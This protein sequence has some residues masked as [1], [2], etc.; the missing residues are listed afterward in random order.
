MAAT[1]ILDRLFSLSGR[2]ALVTGAA[3]GFGLMMARGMAEAGAHVVLNDRDGRALQHSVAALTDEGLEVS[4][5]AFDVTDAAAVNSAVQAIAGQ[6]GRLDI[7]INNAAIQN[8]KPVLE[9]SAEEWRA[10]IETDLTGCFLVAQAAARVM[11]PQGSGRIINIA[12]IV[13][14]VGRARLAP[15]TSA[16][17]GLEGLTRVL[18]AEFGASGITANA[19]APG[20]F[21]TDFNQA[22]LTDTAFVEWVEGRTPTGRWGDPEDLLGA[23]IY[24]ASDAAAYV[25]GA[26]LTVD[27]G[28]VATM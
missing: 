11:Q 7:L 9:Y 15:Y 25:N 24:L 16:K 5:A 27:G 14:H 13:A 28:L 2:T 4:A 21:R 10:I 22:L 19:I 12:S 17:A 26:V 3:R 1:S 6:R 20:Y 8:R 23:V 18:A